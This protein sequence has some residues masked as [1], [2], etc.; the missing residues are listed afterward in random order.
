[1]AITGDPWA[2]KLDQII[3]WELNCGWSQTPEKE[4]FWS[5]VS[6]YFEDKAGC[7]VDMDISVDSTDY[8][9]WLHRQYVCLCSAQLGRGLDTIET[10]LREYLELVLEST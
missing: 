8:R 1:M 5:A 9:T 10:L 3:G 7:E 2:Y 4:H 6:S